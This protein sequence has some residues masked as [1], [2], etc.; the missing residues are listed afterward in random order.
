MINKQKFE[1]ILEKKLNEY[2]QR[3]REYLKQAILEDF[4]DYL[5]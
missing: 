4:K 3:H 2:P 1:K 5:D